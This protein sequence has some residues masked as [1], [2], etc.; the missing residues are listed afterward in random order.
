MNCAFT[1][2]TC[3]EAVDPTTRDRSEVRKVGEFS[4]HVRCSICVKHP[5]VVEGRGTEE[6]TVDESWR[7]HISHEPTV[8]VEVNGPTKKS[9]TGRIGESVG[10]EDIKRV[11]HGD[12]TDMS[13]RSNRDTTVE[14]HSSTR[15]VRV[16]PEGVGGKV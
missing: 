16:K 9:R 1:N 11:T 12:S 4:C 6:S 5:W 10:A 8:D 2:S 14:K 3:T 15:A 13:R 7:R